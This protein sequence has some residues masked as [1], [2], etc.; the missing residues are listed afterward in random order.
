V[1]DPRNL[2]RRA[3]DMASEVIAHVRPAQLGRATPCS[4]WD[5][6]ALINH[7]VGGN[8][9]FTAMVTG[10]PGPGADDDVL[11]SDPLES[12][13][14]SLHQLCSVFGR[15]GFLEQAYPT[16]FGEGPGTV[17]V[18]MRVV[19]L[20]IHSWDLA[21]ASGQPRD[22]DPELVG[23]AD[24]ILRSRP[25]PRGETGPFRPEKPAPVGAPGADRLAAFA[26]RIVPA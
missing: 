15:P 4:E 21:A 18:E 8:L 12:F 20:T 11:G 24:S 10:E 26:G 13:R 2:H 7:V 22:L 23:F 16:P 25:I 3:G 9:R 17:L 19:E 1:A 14:D 6:R 5:L